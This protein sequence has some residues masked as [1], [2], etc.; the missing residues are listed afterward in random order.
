V[1]TTSFEIDGMHCAACASRNERS[2]AR[3]PGV[4]RASVNLASRRAHVD[5]DRDAISEKVIQEA[6]TA[7]GFSVLVDASRDEQKARRNAS[8]RHAWQRALLALIL[9][10]P[11]VGLAMGDIR[12]PWAFA[13]T[14]ASVG[15]QA[16]LGSVVIV[17]FGWPLHRGMIALALRGAASMDTLIS[18]GTLAALGYSLWAILKGMDHVYFE[19]GAVITALI[20]LGRY[21]ETRSRGQ[22]GAAIEKLMDLGAHTA[23][24]VRNGAEI[25]V[26]AADVQVGDLVQIR[27]GE[28]IPVDGNVVSGSSSV[29]E[30]MLT[31]ESMPVLK[32]AGDSVY[33]ATIN[34][35]G[36]FRLRAEKTGEDTALGQI[37]R[38]VA[39]AQNNKAPIE[40]LADRVSAIFV[41]IVLALAALT[42]G[43]W[44]VATGDILAGV[45]PAVAVLVIAC[46]CSLGLAT[47]TAIMVG[48]GL[49]ARR[50]ILIRDGEALERGKAIDTVLFD[51]T[52]TLTEGK[53]AVQAI[54]ADAG[55]SEERLLR[56]AASVESVSEHPLAR[57]IVAAAKIRSL[58]IETPSDFENIAGM[59]TRAQ[60][61]TGRAVVGSPR[62]VAASGAL[63]PNLAEAVSRHESRGHTVV[64]VVLEET[65]LGALA[66]AD[67]IKDDAAQAIAGL[68]A[69]G[70]R[71][72]M[73]T[74]DN[75]R[76]A[77]AIAG[78]LGIGE[79]RAEV[80]PSGKADEVKRFQQ[81]GRRVAFVGDGI[82][83]APALAQAD[84]G[85][86]I[87]TGTDIAME[88]GQVVLV[89]GNPLKVGEAIS[90]SQVTFRT[91][92]QN[93]FWAFFYNVAA[94][95]LAALGLLN[96]MIAAAAMAVSSIS[97][98]GNSLRIKARLA[99]GLRDQSSIPSTRAGIPLSVGSARRGERAAHCMLTG[100]P[101]RPM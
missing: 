76:A 10:A 54:I 24:V 85:I 22:A 5:Y 91:I 13:E 88:A 47:P 52:G 44:Y 93:M 67:S 50:G 12:L 61:S 18:I 49:G 36:A 33:G 75:R 62:F 3:L 69:R 90:L 87:G 80:L 29:D 78:Q 95:P 94:I 48:T 30:S 1:A 84:L 73:I 39:A 59:G 28:K 79:V 32:A 57:A 64:L 41:P 89:K 55:V 15:L 96:P 92:R 81:K 43:G 38:L 11:V 2:L 19:T 37:V 35:S 97:V 77:E 7:N 58:E 83:D 4:R 51:K 8:L 16:I 101:H 9:T 31:G 27:P 86:A 21:L 26:P 17:V 100:D 65:V 63:S 34:L 70:I 20:L 98:V 46:P 6:V 42:V 56:V 74:G 99:S 23:H 71:T 45:I 82:N 25:D 66:I 53:P 40:K 68:H 72:V 14:N 60:L